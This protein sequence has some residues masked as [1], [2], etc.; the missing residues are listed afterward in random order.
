MSE[1]TSFVIV[2]RQKA[3]QRQMETL[4]HNMAN[5]GTTAYQADYLT[6][7]EFVHDQSKVSY[8]TTNH[9]I[10]DLTPGSLEPTKSPLDVAI[11]GEGYFVIETPDGPRYT[12]NGHFS[13]NQDGALV[14]GQGLPVQGDGGEIVIPPGTHEIIISKD[15]KISDGLNEL[16]RINVVKFQNPQDM[17]KEGNGLMRTTQDPEP[18]DAVAVIQGTLEGSNVSPI[19]TM[20]DLM[21]VTNDYA[22]NQRM[23]DMEHDRIRKSLGKLS[24]NDI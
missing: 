18:A 20:T 10:R 13:T 2:A 24:G 6:F 5:Q 9:M 16:G 15:G 21:Q 8:V 23:W 4:A 12:R 11:Q 19:I 3:L 1:S 22:H 17:I 14:N 7:K